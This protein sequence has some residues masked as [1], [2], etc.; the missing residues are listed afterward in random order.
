MRRTL[1]LAAL[2]ALSLPL[3]VA[4]Q[5][6]RRTP[7]QSTPTSIFHSTLVANLPTTTTLGKGILQFEISHR[8][9]P[10]VSRGVNALWGLDGP[11]ED[12]LGL[13]WAPTGRAMVHIERSNLNDNLE[14]GGRIRLAEGTAGG[15]PVAA[16][17]AAGFAWNTDPPSAPGVVD[18]ETQAYAQLVLDAL[19]GG[20]FAVDVVPSV[21]RNPRLEDPDP[22]TTFS[23]GLAGQ[24]Y[25]ARSVSLFGEWVVS[26]ARPQQEHDAGTFGLEL[27]TRGHFFK[28]LMTNTVEMNPT[29]LLA[30]T[31]FPFQPNEWRFGFTITRRFGL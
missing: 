8:F 29:Q 24:A 25:V 16:A 2:L 15:M 17:V 21:L 20:R 1:A 13:S 22:V 3:P 27:Q 19:L 9:V 30:G 5:Q 18:N 28:L 31:P 7:L 12:R 23:L 26:E 10:P 11:A 14:L 4:A 6:P